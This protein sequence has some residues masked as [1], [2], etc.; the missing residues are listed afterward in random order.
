MVIKKKLCD[1]AVV[2]ILFEYSRSDKMYDIVLKCFALKSKIIFLYKLNT[3]KSTI[4]I[5]S[6]KLKEIF[7]K[8][9]SR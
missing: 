8:N 3:S 4:A 2:N 9:L 7:L 5:N 6:A 1:L